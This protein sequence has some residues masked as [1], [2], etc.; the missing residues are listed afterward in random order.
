MNDDNSG[1]NHCSSSNR[2][3]SSRS[4]VSHMSLGTELALSS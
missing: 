2:G 4:S 3:S 1:V